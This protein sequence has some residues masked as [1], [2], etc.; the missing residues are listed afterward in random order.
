MCFTHNTF[1]N[2]NVMYINM[3]C[4]WLYIYI[5]IYIYIGLLFVISWFKDPPAQYFNFLL[6]YFC[7]KVGPGW[8]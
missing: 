4:A 1:N 5:Y 2:L 8:T 3:H 7:V 6:T